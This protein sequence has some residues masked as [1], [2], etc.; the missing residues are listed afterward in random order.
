MKLTQSGSIF[1]L[2]LNPL[3]CL[4]YLLILLGYTSC[5][6]QGNIEN[7]ENAEVVSEDFT[8]LTYNNPD[9]KVDL[10]VG[11]WAWPLPLDYDQ[12]GD[13]DLLVSCPDTPFNGLYFFENDG[14]THEG[15]TAFKPPV[16]IGP[17]VKN[18]QLSYV[19]SELKVMSPGV[20]FQDFRNTLLEAPDRLF[21]AKILESQHEKIRFSQWKY[22]DYEGD[23][24]MDLIVGIDEWGDYGWD[25]AFNEQGNWTNGP[26]HGYVYL[27]ENVDGN[28]ENR[29]KLQ[30][31]GKPLDVYGAPSPNMYDFDGDGDLDLI[32]GEFLDKLT[33]F[34]N[35]GTREK[36]VFAEGRVLKNDEGV[37]K[38]DLEMIIPVGVDWD[39]DGDMDLVIGDEDGRVALVENTGEVKDHMPVFASAVYFKQQAQ[40]V[41]FGALVTPYSVDWDQDGDE[42][43]ICG[44]SAGY[45]AFIENLDGGNPP[46][47]NAPQLLEANGEIIRIMAGDSGSIQGPAESKWGYTTLSVNDWDGDGLPD[48]IVNSIWGKIEWYKNIGSKNQPKL[49]AAQPVKVAWEQQAPKPEWNW[50]NPE[51]NQ[52]STQWRTTPETVDWNEDGLMD[53][54]MLDHEGYLVW[55]ERFERG[56]EK[57]LH[58]GKRIFYGVNASGFDNKH[59]VKD[60]TAGVLRMNV[61]PYGSSGRRKLAVTDWDGDGDKD[62]LVN[63]LNVSLMENL[64]VEDG[65]VSFSNQGALS[66]TK[67]AGHTT[68]PT[69]VDWDQDGQPEL[70]VGAEDGHLYY[71]KRK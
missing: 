24:D 49:A 10:G 51:E 26:L 47:W 50:W 36:P 48:I 38:M 69:T 71:M 42:D 19:E 23:G 21:D 62:I 18:I 46:R 61:N 17:S 66:E 34:E 55:F 7:K 35:T 16:K 53:L 6:S 9:L 60:S 41:K 25:N 37:I 29:G 3:N 68:S 40:N 5:T 45:I 30:A 44:N 14:Q 65:M 67:L 64:G 63:S 15:I 52:L 56:G 11:L 22:V 70:L 58:P 12:D 57:L 39:Q 4:L 43:L 8:L 54:L 33:W 13:M 1:T 27:L 20:E 2:T 28:Y 32:C 31:A 59:G